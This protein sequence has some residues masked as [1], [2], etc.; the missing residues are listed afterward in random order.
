MEKVQIV[1]HIYIEKQK[2]V[3]FEKDVSIVLFKRELEDEQVD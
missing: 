3:D 2:L 1:I